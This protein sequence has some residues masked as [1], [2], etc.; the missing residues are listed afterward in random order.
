M[1]IVNTIY[2]SHQ[3]TKDRDNVAYIVRG[4]SFVELPK[5]RTY[6]VIISVI[7]THMHVYHMSRGNM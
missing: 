7:T 6:F 3:S 5:Q 4:F 1:L 2:N